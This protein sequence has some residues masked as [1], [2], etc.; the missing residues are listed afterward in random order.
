MKRNNC[1]ERTGPSLL[2]LGQD[3]LICAIQSVQ[4]DWARMKE[5][6]TQVSTHMGNESGAQGLAFFAEVVGDGKTF[7]QGFSYE[8]PGL[9]PG[10]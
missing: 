9:N 8:F 5:N 7:F 4:K 2:K 6:A 1:G 3:K 10:S